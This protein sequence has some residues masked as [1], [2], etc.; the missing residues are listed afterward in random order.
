MPSG[1]RTSLARSLGEFFGHIRAGVRA[2]PGESDGAR[3]RQVS[4]TVDEETVDTPRGR[5]TLRR[6]VIEEIE[7]PAERL[8]RE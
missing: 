3:R 7:L 1:K 5:A 8:E 4:R 2:K 6:T